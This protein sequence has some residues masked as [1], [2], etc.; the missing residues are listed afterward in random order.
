MLLA[1]FSFGAVSS[2]YAGSG[3]GGGSSFDDAPLDQQFETSFSG[4]FTT[5]RGVSLTILA[6]GS[7]M[8]GVLFMY[9]QADMAQKV[10]MG[11]VVTS[12]VLSVLS[13][14]FSTFQVS[15]PGLGF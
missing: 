11:T 5:M 13:M 14:I 8:G 4:L 7:V 6:V 1:L 2:S 9:G 10:F 12:S 3:G 15:N